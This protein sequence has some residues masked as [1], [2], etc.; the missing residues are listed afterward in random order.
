[1]A[2]QPTTKT[3]EPQDSPSNNI[4]SAILGSKDAVHFNNMERQKPTI[5]PSGSLIM[6]AILKV[7]S[8]SGLRMGGPA[9][10]GKSSQAF[11]FAANYMKALPKSKTIYINAEFKLSEEL[12]ARTGL[13]FVDKTD[14]WEYGSV[15]ILRSNVYDTICDALYG[16]YRSMSQHG[17]HLCVI[18]DSIDMLIL[19]SD[20]EKTVTDNKKPAGI[21]YITK[22]LFRKIQGYIENYNGF[23]IAITQYS[24]TFK[25]DTY[26][27]TPPQMMEGNQ[28]NAL[29]H[30]CSNALYYRPRF[31]GDYILENPNDKVADPVK[32]K[33]LGVVCKV[34]IKKSTTDQSNQTIEIPIKKG[35]IGNAIWTEK[36]IFD[37]LI[38]HGLI[39]KSGSWFTFDTDFIKWAEED[40]IALKAKHQGIDQFSEYF[41]QNPDIMKWVI[42]KIKL[43][44]H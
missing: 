36:E 41:E 32:N 3:P 31:N 15:F 43:V 34:E 21:N 23:L 25:I 18:I 35:R 17:E 6:D 37:V 14:D 26:A 40:K 2:K 20:L 7:K 4:L 42:E 11:L 13:K 12:Q 16:L 1:M 19:K 33:I 38:Y 24:A 8:G 22:E 28:T 10:V 5:I 39:L 9:E 44:T 29:N 30:M 27:K